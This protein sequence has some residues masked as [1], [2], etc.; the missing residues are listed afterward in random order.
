MEKFM[1]G[2]AVTK[3]RN[4]SVELLRIIAILGVVILHYNNAAIGGAF[5]YVPS[6]SLKEYYLFFT[7]CLFI[8]GVNIFYMIS[9]YYLSKSNKRKLSKV[10][11]L[12]QKNVKNRFGNIAENNINLRIIYII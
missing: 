8:A 10:V 11:D 1:R 6:P 9:A 2:K 3:N 7:E 12:M 5:K 4:S